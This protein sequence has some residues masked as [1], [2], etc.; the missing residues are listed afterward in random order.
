[1]TRI[2]EPEMRTALERCPPELHRLLV[3]LCTGKTVSPAGAVNGT[4]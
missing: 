4:A 2:T 1:M 3:W